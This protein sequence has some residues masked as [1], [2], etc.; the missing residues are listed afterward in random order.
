MFETGH[1]SKQQT[2]THKRI[3]PKN[4]EAHTCGKFKF[5]KCAISCRDGTN[6]QH[7]E[8][9]RQGVQ[10]QLLTEQLLYLYFRA[11]LS[12]QRRETQKNSSIS[13]RRLLRDKLISFRYKVNNCS[14][15][16][17]WD[18][19]HENKNKIRMM[20]FRICLDVFDHSGARRW[21]ATQS[22]CRSIN[23]GFFFFFFCSHGH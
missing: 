20:C 9:L 7:G 21:A 22:Y 13:G 10:V 6:H 11:R 4:L 18:K 23:Q 2:R 1:F 12:C 3:T 19:S 15:G 8:T 14:P 5:F 16:N 17:V